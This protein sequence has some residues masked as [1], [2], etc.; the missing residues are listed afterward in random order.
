M[1]QLGQ[2]WQEAVLELP[3]A[4]DLG[5]KRNS[6]GHFQSWNGYKLHVDVDDCGI[7]ISALTTSASLH[8]SQV[9][10]PLMKMTAERTAVLYQLMDAAEG[11]IVPAHALGKIPFDQWPK[12]TFLDAPVTSG[13]FRLVRYERGTLIELARNPDSLMA[14]RPF[15]DSVVFRIIPEESTLLNE[16]RSG[17][18][19]VMENVP[20]AEVKQLESDPRLRVVRVPDLSY[21]FVC[22]NTK[23]PVF[24]DARVRRALTMAIDRDAIVEGLLEGSGRVAAGP[25]PSL[26]WAHDRELRP[27][28]YDVE[29]ARELLAAAGWG[30]DK[31]LRFE[32]ETSQESGLRTKVAEMIAAQLRQVGV[33]ATLRPLEF[34]AFVE[35]HERHDFDAFVENGVVRFPPP[36][37]AIAFAAQIR[38]P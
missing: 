32:L 16:L 36:R 14:P 35:K 6:K 38:E 13:P 9:A 4:C 11:N 12:T 28:P 31:P 7:P 5:A 15:L 30:K 24:A 23:R 3:K 25:I 34:G 19:D 37:D 22:W 10:I 26:L 8:D 21:T 27:L 1:V 17:G 2:P 33:E 29:Q 18:I 20:A